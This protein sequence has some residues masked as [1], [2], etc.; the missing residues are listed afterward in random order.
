M[1]QVNRRALPEPDGSICSGVEYVTPTNE[2]EVNTLLQSGQK[3]CKNK[4][5]GK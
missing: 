1:L 3:K 2:N 5:I 4:G